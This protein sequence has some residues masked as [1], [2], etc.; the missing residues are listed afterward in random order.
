MFF[1]TS[2]RT[3]NINIQNCV[4]WNSQNY[5]KVDRKLLT[6]FCFFFVFFLL[7]YSRRPPH[8]VIFLLCH[9]SQWEAAPRESVCTNRDLSDGL[10]CAICSHKLSWALILH[11]ELQLR[12]DEMFLYKQVGGW[13]DG[14][15]KP[16]TFPP[17]SWT[18]AVGL[19]KFI[20]G[21]ALS[22]GIFL[23]PLPHSPWT[24]VWMVKGRRGPKE[25]RVQE[26][27]CFQRCRWHAS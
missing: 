26:C 6:V 2:E 22:R 17:G 20:S 10:S 15:L 8:L 18:N 14:G 13:V 19:W 21:H 12:A 3:T 9:H 25:V 27:Y 7:W 11:S 1:Q 5:F 4:K 23:P 16:C 24:S